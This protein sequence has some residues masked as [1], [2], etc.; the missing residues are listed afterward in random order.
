LRPTHRVR[1]KEHRDD[2]GASPQAIVWSWSGESLLVS[3]R[4]ALRMWRYLFQRCRFWV[5]ARL[6]RRLAPLAYS[7]LVVSSRANVERPSKLL[8]VA[9]PDDESLFGGETLTCTSG[10]TVVCVTNASN[11]QRC[12]EF[13]EAMESIHAN[14]TLLDHADH[15]Q[16]GNFGPRLEEQLSALM[17][18]FPYELVVTHNA[19]G[20][21]GHPQHRAVHRLVRR[22]AGQRPL[23]V[24][25]P[26]HLTSAW[27]ST[28][29]RALL[30]RYTSQR[31][32]IAHKSFLAYRERWRRIQ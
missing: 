20:E 32:A 30:D 14:Y 18:E 25:D 12:R 16:N 19:A 1:R 15:L 17:D 9:H 11:K 29:K 31:S 8:I 22:L 27:M 6:H 23:Y 2:R 10:W 28:P 26:A 3:A 13:I 5:A 7:E 4:L 24:F 21:Y